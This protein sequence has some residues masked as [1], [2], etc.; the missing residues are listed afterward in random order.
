DADRLAARY[1]RALPTTYK[2]GTSVADAARDVRCLEALCSTGRAQMEVV[3]DRAGDHALKLYLTNEVLVLSDFVPVL[4]NFGLRVL[5][6]N[7]VHLKLPD[8]E[9]ACIHTF[10][11]AAPGGAD[12]ERAAPRLIA[13]L[14]AVREAAVESDRLNALVVS[15]ALEWRAVDL[16]RAYVEHARQIDVASQQTLIEALTLNPASAAQLF[17]Y[18]AMRFDPAASLLPAPERL[19]GPAAA[20]RARY[21]A[22]I[23][24]VQSL[25]HDRVLRALGDAVESTVRTNFYTAPAGAAIALKIDSAHL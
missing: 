17:A 6:Q 23:D 20:A 15:A 22:G 25:A 5:G 3:I 18:C 10:A 8:V 12:L 1:A 13:A 11:V 7:V 16:L 2:A 19:A 14:H 9:A 4:E 21:L 24:A